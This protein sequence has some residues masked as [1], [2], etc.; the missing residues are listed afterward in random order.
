MKDLEVLLRKKKIDYDKL[1]KYGFNKEN[2]KYIYKK[3][4]LNSEFMIYI[5]ISEN[6]KY[7][8][9]IEKAW[10]DEYSLVD[11]EDAV[12]EFVG[13]VKT[14]YEKVIF[15]VIDKCSEK[16]IFKFDQTKEVIEYVKKKY[17]DELEFLWEKFDDNAIWRNKV[18]N[19]WYG[20]VLT[21]NEEKLGINSD[22]IIE[23]ID[24]RYSK[25]EIE[26][27]IDNKKIFPGYHMN[28]KSWIT[29]K[30][31]NSVETEEII[32]L[33]DNSYELSLGKKK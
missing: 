2:D 4:I 21:V 12:G 29:I 7:S 1:I 30:L 14:E 22:R 13:K 18:N 26:G 28:K 20:L 3:D 10:K 8:K 24:L 6:E 31:D 27:I 23:I 33:I 19:K 15:D 5:S 17:N 25:E 11:V 16:E 32:H 9:V